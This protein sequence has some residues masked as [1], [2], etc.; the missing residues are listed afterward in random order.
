MNLIPFGVDNEAL[1]ENW[2]RK[3]LSDIPKG[4]NILDAGAGDQHHKPWCSHL[5]YISQ[6]LANYD[7]KGNS[8]GLQTGTYDYGKLDIIS[9][10]ISI[11]LKSESFE[12][13]LCSEVLE[14]VLHPEKAIEEM[15]RLI[16]KG[17]RL[18][19]T[20]P[21][22]SL[23]HFAPYHY[24]TGFN[25]YWYREILPLYGLRLIHITA[26]GDYFQYL[27]QELHRLEA[28]ANTYCEAAA[29]TSKLEEDS[30][31]AILRMLNRFSANSEGKSSQLLCYGYLII[32][33]KEK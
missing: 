18:I 15:S 17:G 1:R 10:I 5:K 16:K 8:A 29:M 22:S 6:D 32:G 28:V 30:I 23:T 7:G 26:Y 4:Y 9:D 31:N 14:H 21:F 13:V 27:A 24:D 12:A 3:V 19:L 33:E 2:I 11:P 25:V 20:A